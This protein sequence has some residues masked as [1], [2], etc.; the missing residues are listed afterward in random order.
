MAT[1]QQ[2]MTNRVD[3]LGVTA[4]NVAVQGGNQ[5]VIQLA[6]VKNPAKAAKI[7]GTTGTLQFFD[8]EPDLGRPRSPGPAVSARRPCRR[9]TAC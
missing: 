2:V 7:I 9:S 3:K 1:A 4:P 6:G 8:F 5:I